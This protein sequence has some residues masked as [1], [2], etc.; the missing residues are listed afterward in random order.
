MPNNP[1]S[2]LA[3]ALGGAVYGDPRQQ[4]LG[5]FYGQRTRGQGLKN[6]ALQT[7]ID[8]HKSLMEGLA[9]DPEMIRAL[10]GGEDYSSAK[11]NFGKEQR[12]K[13]SHQ[14]VVDAFSEIYKQD[15]VLH[16]QY[17]VGRT[18]ADILSESKVPYAQAAENRL[19]AKDKRLTDAL[20]LLGQGTPEEKELARNINLQLSGP[21]I[22]ALKRIPSDKNESEGKVNVSNET[23]NKTK[24]EIKSIKKKQKNANLDS[25]QARKLAKKKAL[26][27]G[28]LLRAK[29]SAEETKSS[30]A[31]QKNLLE[32][33]KLN[34]EIAFK[35]QQTQTQKSLE[36]LRVSKEKVYAL[37]N[38]IAKT[39]FGKRGLEAKEY[40]AAIDKTIALLTK[41]DSSYS[42]G[43]QVMHGGELKPASSLSLDQLTEV[44]ENHVLGVTSLDIPEDQGQDVSAALGGG[45]PQVPQAP[46]PDLA[47]ALGGGQVSQAQMDFIANASDADLD[48]AY[49]KAVMASHPI[50]SVLEQALRDRGKL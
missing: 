43:I 50:S 42:E 19:V 46:E 41:K 18:G 16:N 32:I 3:N 31:N 6:Q 15:P 22:R 47:G 1:F 8:E 24:E 20:S 21:D 4:Q 2:D 13:D 29:T 11:G 28:N 48:D 34:A 25:K 33:E 45:V 40:V 26:L 30:S 38:E 35:Q 14:S 7:G 39:R 5:Q 23:V 10:Q 9:G 17:Q 37:K 44:A 49:S 12:A 36:G 27:E